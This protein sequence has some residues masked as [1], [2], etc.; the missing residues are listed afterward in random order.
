M[1]AA[2]GTVALG[3]A[4]LGPLLGLTS[5]L[6]LRDRRSDLASGPEPALRLGGR[7]GDVS[8]EDCGEAAVDGEPATFSD[9]CGPV[10]V[11]CGMDPEPE[12]EPEPLSD[13]AACAWAEAVGVVVVVVVDGLDAG[14]ADST[15]PVMER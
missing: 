5:A 3:P 7:A 14:S 10:G 6:F 12:P 9:D 8:R 2:E 1:A 4:R 15:T 13:G 11:W